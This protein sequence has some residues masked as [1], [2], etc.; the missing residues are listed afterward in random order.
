MLLWHSRVWVLNF[1][2]WE[3]GQS[4]LTGWATL[5]GRQELG[6]QRWLR[7]RGIGMVDWMWYWV[8]YIL[9]SRH[10]QP[11]SFLPAG[12]HVW[13]RGIHHEA[14][15]GKG[16]MWILPVG[17]CVANR[18][19]FRL[20][21]LLKDSS[22]LFITLEAWVLGFVSGRVVRG[23]VSVVHGRSRVDHCAKWSIFEALWLFPSFG[24]SWFVWLL[25]VGGS[26]R[27]VCLSRTFFISSRHGVTVICASLVVIKIRKCHSLLR[28]TTGT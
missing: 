21:L 1:L 11:S 22:K 6:L 17:H 12:L 5:E 27:A 9:A 20:A 2:L 24:L 25:S 8:W 23:D 14:G 15:G 13:G 16:W 4:G 10:R 19:D 3:T 18:G 26:F 7:E 28:V